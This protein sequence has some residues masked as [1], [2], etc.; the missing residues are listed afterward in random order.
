LTAVQGSQDI[1]HHWS[2]AVA[3]ADRDYTI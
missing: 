1:G 3:K 2:E